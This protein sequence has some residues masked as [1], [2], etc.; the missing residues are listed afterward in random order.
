MSAMYPEEGGPAGPPS[1][2][3]GQS[4]DD[5]SQESARYELHVPLKDEQRRDAPHI[6]ASL[7]QALTNAGF[8]GRTI[9]PLTQ[10]DWGGDATSHDTDEMAI[11]MIDAPDTPENLEAIKTAADGVK[12]V[13]GID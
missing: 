6:L 12:Q 8:P 5:G 9:I 7:R 2:S 1:P 3:E 10:G 4:T 11:V 13:S